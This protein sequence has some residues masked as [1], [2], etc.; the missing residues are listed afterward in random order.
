MNAGKQKDLL[1]GLCI[2]E[3]L[4]KSNYHDIK[5]HMTFEQAISVAQVNLS[6]ANSANTHAQ[7]QQ[8]T[9]ISISAEQITAINNAKTLAELK[10]II[11]EMQHP[12]K[13]FSKNLVFSDGVDTAEIMV[14]G[15]APGAEEDEQRKPF[16]GQSGMLLMDI[17]KT[18]G[19]IRESNFYIT[20]ILPWRPPMNQT[21][22]LDEI[23]FF[24]PYV[25]KHIELIN[26]AVLILIGATAYKAI[27]LI[28]DI[29]DKQTITQI[30]GKIFSI[31]IGTCTNIQTCVLLHPSYLLRLPAQKKNMWR[32]VLGLEKILQTL[33]L[34]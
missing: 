31:N 24:L 29:D 15:E 18:I 5:M 23:K 14:I 21:P 1:E 3:L 4:D 27:S 16:V 20:N 9:L 22:S 19:L 13:Q 7:A 32:D 6:K 8:E 26:P 12:F 10:Q 11:Q 2:H 34:L 28:S 33:K 25:K 30:H 17:F